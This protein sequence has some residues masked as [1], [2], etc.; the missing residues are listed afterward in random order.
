MKALL[1]TDAQALQLSE[2]L[3]EQEHLGTVQVRLTKEQRDALRTVAEVNL[4]WTGEESHA[5]DSEGWNLFQSGEYGWTIERDDEAE[6]FAGDFDAV[7]YVASRAEA[8]SFLHLKAL[9]IQAAE[10]N[11][12][13]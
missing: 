13:V 2:L 5:V 9:A 11:R 4:T 3:A 7:D 1:L 8:G 6:A 12:K 10:A